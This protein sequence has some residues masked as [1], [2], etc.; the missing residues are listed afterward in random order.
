MALVVHRL[1]SPA[2]LVLVAADRYQ[3][4]SLRSRFAADAASLQQN[5]K[6]R[7]QRTAQPTRETAQPTG[8]NRQ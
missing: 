7:L 6:Q 1:N 4:L 8:R 3:R 5:F 2:P